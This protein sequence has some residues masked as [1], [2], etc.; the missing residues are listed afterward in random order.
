MLYVFYGEN[1]ERAQG[2]FRAAIDSFFK[3]H[4]D[5]GLFE[6]D[7]ELWD[8]GA[9]EELLAAQG[10]FGTPTVA[11][12]SRV[13]ENEE[14]RDFVLSHL[15]DLKRSANAF[16]MLEGKLLKAAAQKITKHA[17]LAE[18]CAGGVKASEKQNPFALADAV[19]KRNKKD[20]WLSLVRALAEGKPP[21]EIHGMLFWQVKAMILAASSRDAVHAGLNPFVFQKAE[22]SARNFTEE[23][24]K[25]LAGK[26][27]TLYHDARRGGDELP[28]ALEK[29]VL[30]L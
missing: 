28:I 11:T 20:A 23:E 21:E 7:A 17:E 19:G 29:F 5:A 25:K 4:P 2:K 13:L 24:L 10:L 6:F 1:G 12:L 16:F 27:T 30:G 3:K 14:A 15:P 8:R 9:V 22:S 26:L 18:E